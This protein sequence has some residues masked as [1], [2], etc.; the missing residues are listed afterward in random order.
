MSQNKRKKSIG[1]KSE[2]NTLQSV[3]YS[4]WIEK[5][6]NFIS[7]Y[8]I[9]IIKENETNSTSTAVK[10]ENVIEVNNSESTSPQKTTPKCDSNIC[11]TL[12]CKRKMGIS[13]NY[14]FFK[15][16]QTF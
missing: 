14:V 15:Y 7:Q 5:D 4:N 13:C 6:T 1:K 11:S 8:I 2:K 16:F 9:P 10:I 3:N 12:G